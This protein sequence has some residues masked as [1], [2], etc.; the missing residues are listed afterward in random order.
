MSSGELDRLREIIRRLRRE[1][2]GALVGIGDDAA[3]LAGC[4]RGLVLSVDAQVQGVH[5]RPELLGWR[6]VGFRSLVAALSDLAAMG[7][8][9]RAALLA[10]VLPD[11]FPD[12]Q[13]YSLIDGVAEASDSYGSPV[14][15]GNLS[16]GGELSITTTVMG[17]A[18]NGVLT[19]SGAIPGDLVLVTGTVGDA[20]LGLARL[21]AGLGPGAE[22]YVERWRRPITRLQEGRRLL[23]LATAAIDLSDGLL[24]D[25]E[26]VCEASG[27]GALIEADAL[28]L[29]EGFRRLAGELGL[30]PIRLALSGGEQYELLFTASPETGAR[31]LGTSI[32]RVVSEP[33]RVQVVDEQG[34][35]IDIDTPGYTHW[36]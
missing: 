13:L 34:R 11:A 15:G 32:G 4:D 18:P 22:R 19:R 9:P 3:V 20:A 35:P 23:G 27:V 7:A 24:L 16:R 28:P 5:F 36:R 14:V 26:R 17:E 2:D 12:E 8:E 29:G 1:P 25:L 31:E 10:L 33:A 21:Q 6:D 30:D